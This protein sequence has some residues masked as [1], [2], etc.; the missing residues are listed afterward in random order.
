MSDLHQRIAAA[1]DREQALHT[2]T[3]SEGVRDFCGE[4]T[5]PRTHLVRWPCLPWLRAEADRRV[6]AR[7]VAQDNMGRICRQCDR[8]LPCPDLLDVAARCGV[9]VSR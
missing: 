2:R 7:H 6:R 1:L 5:R 3:S 4:C 8:Y 9:E